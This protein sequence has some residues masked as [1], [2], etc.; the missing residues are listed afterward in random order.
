MIRRKL[1]VL[2]FLLPAGLAATALPAAATTTTVLQYVG[3]EPAGSTKALDTSGTVPP[4]NGALHQVAVTG[5]VYSFNGTTSYI[6]TPASAT[7]NPDTSNFTF[8]VSINLPSTLV[9][10]RDISLVRR[11]AAKF[12][13]AYYKM[14]MVYN[15]SSHVMSLVCAFRDQAGNRGFVSTNADTLNDN[16][17]HTLTCSKT[18]TSVSLNKGGTKTYIKPATLGNLSSTQPLNF[19]AEQF[20]ST[21]LWEFFPGLMDNITL[22]KG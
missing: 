2:A 9:F 5:G 12:A 22:T 1:A 15:S 10:S 18:A 6:Q 3:N 19:G 21:T 20:T 11:G 17:W 4:N 8:S 14:E 7:V 16:A 13:G